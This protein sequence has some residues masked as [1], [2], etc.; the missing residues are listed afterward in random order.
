MRSAL[1]LILDFLYFYIFIGLD[2]TISQNFRKFIRQAYGIGAEQLTSRDDLGWKNP[3]VYIHGAQMTAGELIPVLKYYLEQGYEE[4]E[5]YAT[6]YS[7]GKLVNMPE[8][9]LKC[10]YVKEHCCHV[11]VSGCLEAPPEPR[12]E[13][14]K[15]AKAPSQV[16]FA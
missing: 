5:I 13:P 15:M 9:N 14:R 3:I 12:G 6:T 1:F 8:A 2:A 10:V 11:S 4:S 16:K 7:Y